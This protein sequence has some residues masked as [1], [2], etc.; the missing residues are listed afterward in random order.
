MTDLTHATETAAPVTGAER[1]E[2]LDVLRG[3]AVLGI[4]VMNIQAFANIGAAYMNPLALGQPSLGDWIIWTTSHVVADSK[5]MTLFSLLFGSGIVLFADHAMARGHGAA[6]LHYRRMF[7]LWVIG[8]VHAYVFWYGDVLVAYATCG[9]IAFLFRKCR[10]R[11][12]FIVAGISLLLPALFALGFRA[13]V[14]ILPPEA[15]EGM[16]ESWAP[17][18]EVIQEE[19]DAYRGNWLEQMP[20]RAA[21]SAVMQ[22]FVFWFGAGARIGALMLIGMALY[23]LGVV[24][25][26][27]DRRL[28]QRLIV[29]GGS[30]GLVL[31]VLGLL[32]N[33]YC[34]FDL[35]ESMFLGS[36]FNYWGSLGLAAGYLG[37]IALMVQ[38][39][40]L[41]GLR[42]RLGA[43]G[44]MALSNY[45][46]QTLIFTTVF[47]GHGLGL[48]GQVE[49]WQQVLMVLAVWALQLWVSPWW[50]QRFRFGPAEWAWRSLTY[51]KLQP[52]RRS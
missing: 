3:F 2:T 24:T 42:R 41:P 1:I 43:A 52:L 18:A 49:R 4:L 16:N 31:I 19:V 21:A 14:E 20:Q 10:P 22:V 50:L 33:H 36:Q 15:L 32:H 11:T 26:A 38:D 28:Y 7:W 37:L 44:R 13:V 25:G 8:M 12:L 34:H 9:A 35:I 39:G 27:R 40:S 23:R 29:V 48:Y 46:G 6:S 30:L 5:F 45:L 17:S 47:Y 51:A